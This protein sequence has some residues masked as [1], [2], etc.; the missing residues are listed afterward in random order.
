M[1]RQ[2]FVWLLPLYLV[3]ALAAGVITY[4]GYGRLVHTFMDNQMR[5]L[6]DSYLGNTERPLIRPLTDKSIHEWGPFIVQIW[7]QDG[8]L[9]STSWAPLALPLQ[10]TPGFHD[11]SVVGGR[12]RVYTAA[13]GAQSVQIVQSAYF[14][15]RE[16]TGLALYASLPVALLLP[17]SML[18]L[19]WVVAAASRSLKG[20]ANEV[21]AQ[22]ERSIAELPLARVPEEITPLVTSFNALLIRLR[23]AFFVQRRFVQDAAHELRTPITA[24]GLQLENLRGHIAAGEAARY[25]AQLEGGVRRAQRLVEQ[26]LKLSRQDA[27]AADPVAEEVALMTVL[28]ESVNELIVLAERRGIDLGLVAETKD[29][30]DIVVTQVRPGDLRSIFDSVIENA[31]RYS[32]EKGAVDV[33]VLRNGHDLAVEVVDFGPGLPEEMLERVFDRFFRV[34]GTGVHG[35]GLGL[36][37]A[38][39]AAERNG[40]RISL[41]NRSDGSGLICRVEWPHCALRQLPSGQVETGNES[42]N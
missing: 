35:S 1:R 33:R 29:A 12:W 18:V 41:R 14:R 40:L 42:G 21:A 39:A 37:I 6:A 30:K 7:D 17:L 4:L 34:P 24:I 5:M 38:R 22:D 2:L 10:A 3:V 20:I 32:H 25:F 16:V 28:H 19:W 9:L 36:A 11:V 31:L 13:A 8:R 23:E 26:L 27:A 15:N